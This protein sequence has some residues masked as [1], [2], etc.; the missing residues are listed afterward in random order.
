[1][2]VQIDRVVAD[3][4]TVAQE[5]AKLGLTPE[6]VRTVAERAAAARAEALDIDPRGSA[7]WD[8]YRHG[9]RALRLQLRDGWR[10][11]RTNN[12][13]SIVNDARGIQLIFQ[14]VDRAC[15]LADPK[16]ISERGAGCR[17]L[18]NGGQGV[19]FDGGGAEIVP[20]GTR[21]T[22][23]LVCVSADEFS[24]RAEV[25]CPESFEGN[26][27]EG[28]SRRLLVVDEMYDTPKP[29]KRDD[30]GRDEGDDSL[31]VLVTKK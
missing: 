14:N 8:S 7:G 28:F 13:E 6:I 24:M 26:Q 21:P 3:P 23:W 25:S 15:G 18:V 12:V 1:M 5:L 16:A 11:D 2:A 27:F 20:L 9:H 17:N 29:L 22:V 30:S 31:D 19:L 10:I 4:R